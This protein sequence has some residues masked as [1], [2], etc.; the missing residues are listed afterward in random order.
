M[1]RRLSAREQIA[2]LLD[3]HS[4]SIQKAFLEAITEIVSRVTLALIVDR[5]E[6][7]DIA[8]A[9][10]ALHIERQA[11]NPVLDRIAEAYNAGGNVTADN[12]ALRSP[13]GR[14]VVFR[15]DVR[16]P[17]AEQ[18]LRDHSSQLV[19]NIVEDQ[20]QG[21]RAA[22]AEGLSIGANPRSTALNIVGRISKVTGT[23]S[24]GIIGL[25]ASQSG[26][27]ANARAELLS[28]DPAMLR[29]YLVRGRR[30]KGPGGAFDKAVARA[31]DAQTPLPADMVGKMLAGYSNKLLQLRGEVIG[32]HETAL[33][34]FGARNEAFRQA[35]ASGHVAA[36]DVTKTWRHFPS[37]HPRMQHIEMAGKVVQF[38]QP[39]ILPDGTP[40]MHPHDS[41]APASQTL[42]CK[43]QAD[44]SVDHI[45]ALVRSRLH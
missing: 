31:I 3:Q 11:F 45:G 35:I 44:Y 1:L 13:E 41:S 4:V 36:Q 12:L 8:G 25:T 43:C 14:R 37:E 42:F 9:I 5:L 24:G 33:S 28:G 7:G 40:M 29:A 10:D 16:N 21:I 17:A 39:F 2:I 30:S 18:W 15:F 27:V 23:R 6:K 34:L 20:R 32:Q 22:L 38:N 26:Y 19:T